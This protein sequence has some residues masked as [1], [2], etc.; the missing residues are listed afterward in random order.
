MQHTLCFALGVLIAGA[1]ACKD[2]ASKA[3]PP[4]A[5]PPA[6]AASQPASQPSEPD[7][8]RGKKHVVNVKYVEPCPDK[9]PCVC[10]GTITHGQNALAKI[11]VTEPML[12]KGTPCV[13][14]D[15][16]GN[17]FNDVVVYPAKADAEPATA[18]MFD[19]GGLSAT[20]KLPKAAAFI[21]SRREGTVDVMFLGDSGQLF[22]FR[23]EAFGLGLRPK[24]SK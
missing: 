10:R 21:E 22:V 17:S 11:G 16:D 15:F 2:P 1:T 20:L 19:E 6:E 12:A 24:S 18:L 4:A 9:A 14:G 13:I 8:Y 3:P 7:I 5:E 23:N